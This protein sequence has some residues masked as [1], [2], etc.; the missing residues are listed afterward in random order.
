MN[1]RFGRP[2]INDTDNLKKIIPQNGLYNS[3]TGKELQ[4]NIL[5]ESTMLVL[6]RGFSSF[7]YSP[8]LMMLW[9]M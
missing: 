9:V 6:V 7:L 1:W 4:M 2:L 5:N 3:A 8:K